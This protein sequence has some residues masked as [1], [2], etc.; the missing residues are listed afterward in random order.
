MEDAGALK[1][2]AALRRGR[3]SRPHRREAIWPCGGAIK[4]YARLSETS[5][6]CQRL[7]GKYISLQ[8]LADFQLTGHR[9]I[10]T[11]TI[12]A[13]EKIFTKDGITKGA[14]IFDLGFHQ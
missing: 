11:R 1:P 7:N 13:L 4:F 5:K 9:D 10:S 14:T 2:S 6:R 3:H 12:S 8:K